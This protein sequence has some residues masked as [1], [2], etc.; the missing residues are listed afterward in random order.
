MSAVETIS[1]AGRGARQGIRAFYARPLAWVALLVTSASLA[2]AGGGVMFWLHAIQR[3]EAGP[4]IADVW[5]WLF[6]STLGFLALSP[7]LFLILPGAL[8]AVHRVGVQGSRASSAVY[9]ALVGVVFGVVTGP[10]PF[11]HDVLV[12]RGTPLARLAVAVFGRDP[13]V[14]AR[15]VEA[16]STLSEMALQV[17]VGTPVYVATALLSLAVVQGW[18]GRRGSGG[19]A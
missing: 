17:L 4:P 1:R 18:A 8:A 6:D 14:A 3:G 10:G 13:A 15:H 12:G 19:A 11:L 9:V 5:H 2:Y 16:H 7:A